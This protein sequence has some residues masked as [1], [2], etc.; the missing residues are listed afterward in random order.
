MHRVG[1]ALRAFVPTLRS[2]G[3]VQSVTV[4][5]AGRHR[6]RHLTKIRF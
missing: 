2:I 3:Y 5:K 4:M 6:R 1:T